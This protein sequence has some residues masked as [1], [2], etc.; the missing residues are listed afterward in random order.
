MDKKN[1]G[2]KGGWFGKEKT[3]SNESISITEDKSTEKKLADIIEKQSDLIEAIKKQ[4]SQ[5]INIKTGDKKK[6]SFWSYAIAAAIVFVVIWL[7]FVNS[8]WGNIL[9][10]KAG[11][12]AVPVIDTI[13][14][15]FKNLWNTGRDFSSWKNPDAVPVD[16]KEDMGIMIK[17]FEATRELYSFPKLDQDITLIADV[18]SKNLEKETDVEFRC[19]MTILNSNPDIGSNKELLL[20]GNI[21]V[22]P[23]ETWEDKSVILFPADKDKSYRVLCRFNKDDVGQIAMNPDTK[24]F[25]GIALIKAVYPAKTRSL[26]RI[27]TSENELD[28]K[29]LKEF[30]SGLS[31]E[32]LL[33]NNRVRAQT[34][35]GAMEGFM[36]IKE[37]QPI[38]QTG[39]YLIDIG[40][41]NT[42][43]WKGKLFKLK[44]IEFTRFPAGV[45]IDY[46]NCPDF[47]NNMLNQASM[48]GI[49]CDYEDDRKKECE[50]NA[51]RDNIKYTCSINING[52]NSE[53]GYSY[54][55]ADFE[56][57]YVVQR[58]NTINFRVPETKK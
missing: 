38:T 54:I 47:E 11:T 57:D 41:K 32:G 31:K 9:M 43:G 37:N 6:S 52:L 36:D 24:S 5:T 51:D 10:A 14:L 48:K 17:S 39:S 19:A 8:D 26:L 34:M 16:K 7:L 53:V 29:Q 27:Y 4:K 33:F 50:K 20:S 45:N 42:K 46:E 13:S 22:Q 35:D 23:G 28:E 25:S 30:R 56:Y 3:A 40:L 58:S 44:T 18:E 2:K 21:K 12:S 1:I 49:N 15:F 55:Q